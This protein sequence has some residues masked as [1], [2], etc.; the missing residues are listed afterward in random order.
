MPQPIPISKTKIIVPHRRPEL[1]SRPRLLE[2]LNDLLDN[3]LILIS[4]PAGYGKTSLMIDLANHVKMPVCWLSVDLLDRDPQ[5]FIAYLIASLAERFPGIGTT[6]RIQLNQLKS[7]E[8][9]AEALLVTLTNEIYEQIE[10]DFLLIIDDYHLLDDVPVI[11]ALVN[12]FLELVVENCHV[13]L[14]SR[15]LPSLDDVTLMVAREQVAGISHAELAFLPREIQALYSQNYHEHLSDETAQEFIKQTGGWITGMVLSNLP[16]M[17]RIS[18]VDTFSYLG[19]QVLDQQPGH[20]REFLLRTSLPDEFS[21]ELCEIVLGP[22]HAEPPNW[23]ELM[24]F[25]LEKNLFVLPLESDGRWLRYHPLFREFLQTRLKEESPQEVRPILERLVKAYEKVGEWEKAYYTCKQLDDLDALADV[26]ERAGTPMLQ[27]AF[28]TLEGWINS[29]PPAMVQTRP[30]LISLRGSILAVKGSLKESKELLD[31]AVTLYR[32]NRNVEGL[33]LAFIRR[34]NTLRVMGDYVASIDDVKDALRLSGSRTSY[35]SHYAE[36][37]RL[38]G[39]NL[40]RLGESR[41]AV[42][43]L[44][45]SLSLYSALN[46]TN[47]IPTLLMETGMVHGAVGDIE[48]A[49]RSYQNALKIRQAEK[50]FYSQAEILNNLAVL[51][52]QVGEYELASETFEAGLACARRSRNRH[53][54]SLILAGLGDLYSEVEE[55]DAAFQAYRQAK[56][57]AGNLPGL[58]ITNYLVVARCNLALLQ[59]KL[60]DAYQFIKTHR[61]RM[62]ASQSA[63]ERGLWALLEGRYFLYKDEPRKAVTLLKESREFFAQ[64]GRDLELQWSMVWLTAAYEQAGES[65]NARSEIRKF[66]S[67]IAMPD[68]AVLIAVRQAVPLLTK[69]QN[70]QLVGRQ[71]STLIEKTQ[72]LETNLPAI[73]RTLRRHAS[74]IQVPSASLS[75]RAFG[76]PEVSVNG[77]VIQMSEWR[78]QSVRDLFFYFLSRQEAVTKEQVGAA[79]WPETQNIQALKARFKNEIYRLRRAAGKDTIVFDDEY[80]RFN[81]QMDYEYDVEAFDSHIRRANKTSDSNARIEH[82]QKAVD[83]VQGP[84]LADVGDEWVVPE[85]ER[86]Q[87]AYSSAL[88]EL[89]YLYLNSNQIERCLLICQ[90]ALK[91]NRFHEMIY[92]IEMRAHAVQGD[93]SAVARRYWA[94]KSAMDE[95]GIPLSSETEQIYRE[96]TT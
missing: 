72:R 14:S 55:F 30:G 53:A 52:H 84:Y 64:D 65:S 34:A 20:I 83:L 45:H 37:L 73:R 92:Q 48:L 54:E 85:R 50:N 51:Y 88:E 63:Y 95:L 61:K 46:E 56:D 36:A 77:R 58:F 2:S 44:E 33:I 24:S 8:N 75:I 70:D 69:L 1:L 66:F 38:K 81:H 16:G 57:I 67:A 4:A 31:K 12:R 27:S 78:T 6:S 79:L 90:L 96:L 68:H 82:L 29:L 71:L 47:R 40:Y 35:Q 93:R 7:I 13:I 41:Q 91:Q 86:L 18:G 3:K 39:L 22:F 26:V 23:Y 74:F 5:R 89:A 94:G 76:N 43:S 11:S 28:V 59:G 32:K 25:I 60:E 9:D 17:P 49:R 15:T 87:H 10:E 80:Y 19:R 21:A 62:K 42:E